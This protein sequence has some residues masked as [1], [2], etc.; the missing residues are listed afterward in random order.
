MQ[1]LQK[2]AIILFLFSALFNIQV[3]G[4]NEL[5]WEWP[6]PEESILWDK[7]QVEYRLPIGF[8]YM[9]I[10][11]PNPT[12]RPSAYSTMT[13]AD[14]KFLI[15]FE[16]DAPLK[17]GEL[18]LFSLFNP[19]LKKKN[20]DSSYL[21]QVEKDMK[22]SLGDKY[23]SLDKCSIKLKY[24]ST[25]SA[26]KKFNADRALTYPLLLGQAK[27][28]LGK[29][30][31]QAIVLQK[32]TRGSIKMYCYYNKMK[33]KE[34]KKY[35]KAAEEIFYFRNPEDFIP[36]PEREPIIIPHLKKDK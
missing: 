22:R 16:I 33:K 1:S 19:N 8:E 29:E 6:G 14:N 13:S 30:Y 9:F 36:Y 35:L 21:I 3:S 32:N 31:C 25:K 24:Y 20:Q 17:S 11:V 10:E 7:Q 23:I 18:D 15:V 12:T 5:K 34:L 4:Q 27:S 26:K 28:F 2:F